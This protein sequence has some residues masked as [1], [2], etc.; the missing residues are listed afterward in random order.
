MIINIDLI[1][2]TIEFQFSVDTHP[3]QGYTSLNSINRPKQTIEVE[4]KIIVHVQRAVVAESTA[5]RR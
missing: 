2:N 1:I 4:I 3:F 5:E